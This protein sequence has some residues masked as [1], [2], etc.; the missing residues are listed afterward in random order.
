MERTL[1]AH[2]VKGGD[3]EAFWGLRDPQDYPFGDAELYT[4]LER[5]VADACGR[6]RIVFHYI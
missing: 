4:R 6:D 3:H 1:A 5:Q 2:T